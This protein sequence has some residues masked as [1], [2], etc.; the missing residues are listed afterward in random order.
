MGGIFLTPALQVPGI[1][2][3]A[4][5]RGIAGMCQCCRSPG[6][7]FPLLPHPFSS[8]PRWRRA[9]LAGQAVLAL[10]APHFHGELLQSRERSRGG[11]GAV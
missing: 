7:L 9:G 4:G 10:E 11:L 1:P 6:V 3:F 5:R 2:C 8:V